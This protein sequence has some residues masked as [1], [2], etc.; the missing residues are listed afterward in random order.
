[1]LNSANGG[2]SLADIA[3][4][5]GDNNHDDSM[6]GNGASWWII[7]LFLFMFC[8]WGNN[9][10]G[11]NTR[12]TDQG[13][14][15]R[16]DLCQDMNFSDLENGVRGVRTALSDGFAN[17]QSSLC[18]GFAEMESSF[19]DA[20]Y[21]TQAGINGINV[22]NMQNMNA[23]QQ[24]LNA[25][26]VAN[27]QN[28]T[29]VQQDINTMNIANMQNMNALQTQI[30]DCCCQNKAA[31]K[32][33]QYQLATDTCAIQNTVQNTTRD[34]IDNQNANTK[35]ILDFIIN[36]KLATLQAE[37]QNLRLAASQAAQNQ[38]LISELRPSPIPAYVTC[39]PLTSSYGLG[40][41]CS[42]ALA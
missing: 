12:G 34:I 28:T 24:D 21:Q 11:N 7:I 27:M 1:M 29:A 22:A 32:D 42:S 8:G 4:A 18:N 5:T 9:G 20:S 3:A 40:C 38:Y 15:T 33:A 25:M 23:L 16:A 31:L 37:N 14:L 10:W 39:N 17:V 26:N 41:G 13:W 6:W 2:Y 19:K 35:S 30:A 36:D